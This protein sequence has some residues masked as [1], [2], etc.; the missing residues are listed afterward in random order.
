[1]LDLKNQIFGNNFK[2]GTEYRINK[3]SL[4][5]GLHLR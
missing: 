5:F 3:A 1:M 4:Q 2:T